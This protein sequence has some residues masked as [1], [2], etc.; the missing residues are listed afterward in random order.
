[1][2]RHGI[3]LVCAETAVAFRDKC[4]LLLKDPR[5]VLET[6]VHTY[7]GAIFRHQLRMSTCFGKLTREIACRRTKG[8]ECLQAAV[9]RH[10]SLVTKEPKPSQ[11]CPLPKKQAPGNL[12]RQLSSS[13]PSSPAELLGP[14]SHARGRPVCHVVSSLCIPPMDLVSD[15]SRSYRAPLLPLLSPP[16]AQ[17]AKETPLPLSPLSNCRALADAGWGSP[18]QGVAL[19]HNTICS[20]PQ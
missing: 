19:L 17:R 9:L 10:R 6:Q 8:T 12:H 20:E 14:T 11:L 2:R 1:M 15:P 5:L 4:G 7:T 13:F 18:N 16:A 3:L